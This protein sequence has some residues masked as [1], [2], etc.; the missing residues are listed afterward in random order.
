[1]L[2]LKISRKNIIYILANFAFVPY[3]IVTLIMNA[4]ALYDASNGAEI[5]G[6]MVALDLIVI[7]I[8]IIIWIYLNT[9]LREFI[10]ESNISN[11]IL[12]TSVMFIIQIVPIIN[13][14]DDFY[15]IFKDRNDSKINAV[16]Y[17]DCRKYSTIYKEESCVNNIFWKTNDLRACVDYWMS[18]DLDIFKCGEVSF[19]SS[20]VDS[21]V[22][23]EDYYRSSLSCIK[24][25]DDLFNTNNVN[26]NTMEY[27]IAC[28]DDCFYD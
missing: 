16:F 26:D 23:I 13:Y 24:S 19:I 12:F 7:F 6:G 5:W 2:R 17:E 9:L 8:S 20:S 28:K 4:K 3:M 11:V 10:H 14:L 1:M 21:I 18:E 22:N 27:Y 25:C 15:R